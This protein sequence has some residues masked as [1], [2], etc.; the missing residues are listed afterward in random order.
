M[1]N[2]T[3]NHIEIKEDVSKIIKQP[4]QEWF[5]AVQFVADEI[6]KNLKD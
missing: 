6:E 5:H 3:Q 1:I 2:I 4:Y